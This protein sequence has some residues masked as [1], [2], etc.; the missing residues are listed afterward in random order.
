MPRCAREP[1]Q[2]GVARRQEMGAA[3][4]VQLKPMLDRAQKAVRRREL[5]SVVAPDVTTGSERLEG[6]QRRRAPQRLVT[7]TVYEL[8]ELHRELDI[9]Q[10]AGSELHL[11]VDLD[12]GQVVQHAASHRLHVRD[13]A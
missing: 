6:D 4:L 10:T 11:A 2:V 7:A 3:Q 9:A 8:Q 5:R 13:K 1:A 12:G